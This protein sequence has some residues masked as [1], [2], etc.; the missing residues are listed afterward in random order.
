MKGKYRKKRQTKT[1]APRA[2][3]DAAMPAEKRLPR[4]LILP[5][6]DKAVAQ[7]KNWVDENEL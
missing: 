6:S 4:S 2:D 5:K 3:P 1:T 7:A